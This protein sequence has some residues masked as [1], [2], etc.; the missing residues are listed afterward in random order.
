MKRRQLLDP[1]AVSAKVS[2]TF[3]KWNNISALRVNVNGIHKHGH[4]FTD[5]VLLKHCFLR[6]RT[7][8]HVSK[9][10]LS[11]PKSTGLIPVFITISNAIQKFC[12]RHQQYS[13][14]SHSQSQWRCD[15][16]TSFRLSRLYISWE[17]HRTSIGNR[18]LVL[19]LL[20]HDA[21]VYI[22]YV[23]APVKAEERVLFFWAIALPQFRFSLNASRIRWFQYTTQTSS[24]CCEWSN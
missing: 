12:Q 11:W 13:T 20:I 4:L 14:S 7:K 16:N 8:F 24:R 5:H 10:Q 3:S 2:S 6:S 1:F 18:Y 9:N 23:Y 22:H 17:N 15:D 19:R 21:P